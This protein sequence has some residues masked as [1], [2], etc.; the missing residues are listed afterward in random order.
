M[1][2][3]E[4]KD[5][6]VEINVEP[7]GSPKQLLTVFIRLLIVWFLL[8]NLSVILTSL[9]KATTYSHG[10]LFLLVLVPILIGV[11]IGCLLLWRFSHNAA[12]WLLNGTNGAAVSPLSADEL[13]V[14]GCSL[15]GLWFLGSNVPGL[16]LSTA[17]LIVLT[18]FSSADTITVMHAGFELLQLSIG[19]ILL[20]GSKGIRR[21]INS[22]RRD[23]GDAL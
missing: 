11:A 6:G 15:L 3:E 22:I 7:D 14:V 5:D 19:V 16:I 4:E 10:L 13:F 9:E 23:R 21:L 18:R 20:F 1:A 12:D 2:E 17:E 8:I